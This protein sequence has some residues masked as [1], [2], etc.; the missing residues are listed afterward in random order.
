VTV[1]EPE[2]GTLLDL[3]MYHAGKYPVNEI[4]F[5]KVI[6][7]YCYM[8]YCSAG[9]PEQID[10]KISLRKMAEILKPYPQ[11]VKCHNKYI[12]NSDK[13][14]KYNGPKRKMELQ[15]IDCKTVL[16]VSYGH[17]DEIIGLIKNRTENG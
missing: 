12:V 14:A 15:L 17:A 2:P 1:V 6:G 10:L 8:Y 7:N 5:F 9:K 11:F 3:S 16:P 13:I 4:L